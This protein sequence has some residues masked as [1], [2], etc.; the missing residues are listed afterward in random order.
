MT[1]S[2]LV[3]TA[4][5][6]LLGAGAAPTASAQTAL[7]ALRF[8]DRSAALG[9]RS[10]GMAGLSAFGFPD[11]ASLLTN[12]AGLGFLSSSFV[13]GAFT[14]TAVT[15]ESDIAIGGTAAGGGDDET[16][17]GRLGSLVYAGRVPTVRGSL[18]FALGLQQ[19]SDFERAFATDGTTSASSLSFGLVDR[20]LTDYTVEDGLPTFSDRLARI[21]YEGGAIDY[22]PGD[23]FSYPFYTAVLPNTT[24]S[25]GSRVQ[26][27]GGLNEVTAAAAVEIA[28]GILLGGGLGLVFGDYRF[29]QQFTETDVNNANG[30]A[31]YTLTV[32]GV[33]YAGFQSLELRD[34]YRDRIAG[35]NAR[36]GIALRPT[37]LPIRLGLG[38]ETPTVMEVQETY[39]TTLATTFDNGRTLRSTDFDSDLGAGDYTYRYVSPSR[40]TLGIATTVGPVLIGADFE[41]VDWSRARFDA[42]DD[43][44]YFDTTNDAIREGLETTVTTRVGGELNLGRLALRAGYAYQPDPRSER[45]F[46]GQP[47]NRERQTTTFGASLRV[48]PRAILDVSVAGQTYR[49]EFEPYVDAQTPLAI[50]NRETRGS[51]SLGLRVGL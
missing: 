35:A 25:Q 22:V 40:A 37:G 20:A 9:M 29:V 48:A 50:T 38:L 19:T 13:G 18:V 28:P 11:A 6:A 17:R 15:T 51:V 36:I 7:D 27:S 46:N 32:D 26:H 34:T 1:S 30:A 49:D 16:T 31:D 23:T 8:G 21:G 33:E 43:P 42:P 10:A 5:V 2:L 3:R 45:S 4:A 39:N 14:G 24:V 12:P 47:S 41:A 44:G